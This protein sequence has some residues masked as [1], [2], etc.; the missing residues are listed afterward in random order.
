MDLEILANAAGSSFRAAPENATLVAV[1]VLVAVVL[2]LGQDSHASVR[3]LK[4]RLIFER[5][6]LIYQQL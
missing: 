5:P 6:G 1:Y 3:P 2:G 4:P